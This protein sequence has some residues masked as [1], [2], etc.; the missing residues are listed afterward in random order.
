[1]TAVLASERKRKSKRRAPQRFKSGAR[2]QRRRSAIPGVRHDKGFGP[3]MQRAKSFVWCGGHIAPF[4]ITASRLEDK[5]H[6]TG[7]ACK[8]PRKTIEE[9][10]TTCQR[11]SAGGTCIPGSALR[12]CWRWSS[13]WF[14]TSP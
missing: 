9:L 12:R 4:V 1:M 3:F 10:P 2:E 13:R 8:E 5:Y 11:T 14:S 7:C 6:G